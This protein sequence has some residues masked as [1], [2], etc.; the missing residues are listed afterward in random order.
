MA[1]GHCTQQV[2]QRTVWHSMLTIG[3]VKGAW[4]AHTIL[5]LF[6]HFRHHSLLHRFLLRFYLW[7]YFAC[8][9]LISFLRPRSLAIIMIII[10][11]VFICSEMDEMLRISM[12]KK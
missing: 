11:F 2:K 8:T 7:Q 1:S 4:A 6:V 5:P 9:F 12:E 10:N 3:A